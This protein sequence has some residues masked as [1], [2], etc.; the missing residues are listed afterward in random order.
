MGLYA[1]Q[2]AIEPR[3]SSNLHP[4]TLSLRKSDMFP[5]LSDYIRLVAKHSNLPESYLLQNFNLY[6]ECEA[7]WNMRLEASYVAGV[8]VENEAA[9]R[10]RLRT[11]GI[12]FLTFSEE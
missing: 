1:S 10:K 3:V 8:I 11:P 7:G 4:I 6:N 2:S 5:D 9:A 12:G